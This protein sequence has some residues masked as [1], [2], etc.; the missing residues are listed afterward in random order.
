M[1]NYILMESDFVPW[2]TVYMNNKSLK[3][4]SRKKQILT[5]SVFLSFSNIHEMISISNL[6][7][8]SISLLLE[9]VAPL[10]HIKWDF[11]ETW[12][13]QTDVVSRLHVSSMHLGNGGWGYG[14]WNNKK[15]AQLN[16]SIN[17]DKH[18]YVYNKSATIF[19]TKI[20]K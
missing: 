4:L 8:N 2:N 19:H 6:S 3:D 5:L 16:Y 18:V 9:E 20:H 7:A 15:Q 17:T 10:K 14:A 1:E 13:L 11:N 12:W